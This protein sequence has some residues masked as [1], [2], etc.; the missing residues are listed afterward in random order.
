MDVFVALE[1]RVGKLI[2]AYKE[3]QVRVATL[4]GENSEL[5]AGGQATGELTSR[6]AELESERDEVR[7]RLEKLLKSLSALDI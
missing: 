5:R 4:E 7:A 3:L 1:D 2:A 6:I